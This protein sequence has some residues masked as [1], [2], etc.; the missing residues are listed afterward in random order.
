M[1]VVREALVLPIM[2]LTVTLL[3][4]LRVGREMTFVPPA[5]IALVLG[6]LTMGSLI[7]ARAFDPRELLNQGRR[8]LENL[9]G[10]VVVSALA[11]A[12][13]QVFNLL[14]P[15]RGL[16]H[17]MFGTV[18]FVQLLSTIA[19]TSDRRAVLRSLSVVLGSA[20]V[21]R[22]IVLESLYA[23]SGGA[24]TRAITALME[25]FSLGAL[26]YEPNDSATGYLAFVALCLY[27][28]AVFL[29]RAHSGS[30][31]APVGLRHPPERHELH[32]DLPAFG[33]ERQSLER[34]LTLEAGGDPLRLA[35]DFRVEILDLSAYG[36]CALPRPLDVL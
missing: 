10:L 29:L 22:Y 11:T 32:R 23:R 36:F 7:R 19:G 17:V 21:L 31:A 9:S 28:T 6:V 8:P 24:L 1:S 27:L 12:S 16:L 14:T 30:G 2:F 34:R 18:F 20:F 13:V 5:L 4:G 15:E 25:G 3:G 26:Q 35:Q 33:R